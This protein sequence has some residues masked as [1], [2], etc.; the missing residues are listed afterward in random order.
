MSRFLGLLVVTMF[1]SEGCYV[2]SKK[3]WTREETKMQTCRENWTYQ[4][5]NNPTQIKVLL[6][7]NR[8]V[9]DRIYPAFIIGVNEQQDTV[10]FID[11]DFE[12]IL[13]VNSSVHVSPG[14]WSAI[15]KVEL[16]PVFSVYPKSKVNDFHC[17]V[18][19]V[20][21]SKFNSN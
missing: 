6:F 15:K 14:N 16:E 5:L 4:D 10:A 20:Y 11:K 1:L 12:G 13:E 7:R 21:F 18:K 8:L 19:V 9:F 17:A 3:F 2:R